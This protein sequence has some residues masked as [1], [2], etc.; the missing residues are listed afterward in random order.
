MGKVN[1]TK[2]YEPEILER[3]HKVHVEMLKDF[4]KVCKK[5]HLKYF[6]VYGTAI[7]AVR[8]QG[9]IPWDDDIDVGMLREDFEKFMEVA[10]I[11]LGEYYQIMSPAK[12]QKSAGSVVKLQRKGTRFISNLTK[13]FGYEQ[14]IFLDIFPFDFAAPTEKLRKRQLFK[15]TYLDRLIYLCGT[16]Y[17][18][19]PLKGIVGKIAAGV[20]W[21][22]HYILKI[23]HISPRFL[24]KCFEKE[25]MRYNQQKGEFVTCF[26]QPTAL[27]KMFCYRDMFPLKEVPFEDT[28]IYILYNNDEALRKVYGDYM[29]VP[30]VDKQVNHCPYIL[31]F[32]GEKPIIN[33]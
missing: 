24:Y 25:S 13:D 6:A 23:F 20:C 33:G 7:G 27:K 3:L 11:E 2:P 1:M 17:P 10:E 12:T 18:L 21:M 19:I 30:P 8:H 16:A 15:T 5:H 31:Q 32:E 22:I 14:C 9:F 28:T 26:G 4:Q 29:Q